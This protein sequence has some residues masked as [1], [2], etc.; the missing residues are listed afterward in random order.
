MGEKNSSG[1]IKITIDLEMVEDMELIEAF[2][3]SARCPVVIE[4]NG[5]KMNMKDPNGRD[6]YRKYMLGELE[7][8]YTAESGAVKKIL[9]SKPNK[10]VLHYNK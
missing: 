6:E 2:I 7:K 10:I 5:K 3:N 4:K 8:E 1:Q 9:E